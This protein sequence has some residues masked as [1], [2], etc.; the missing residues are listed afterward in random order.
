MK[1]KKQNNN[2][3]NQYRPVEVII[4]IVS[5]AIICFIAGWL[6]SIKFT[7]QNVKT[8]NNKDEL[9]DFLE[10]YDT[11]VKNYYGEVDK[12]ALIKGAIEGMI[13][14]L[15]DTNTTYIDDESSNNFNALLNGSYNGIGVEIAKKDKDIII[16]SVFDNSP[17]SNSGLKTGDIIKSV[18]DQSVDS[19]ST[20]EVVNL[21]KKDTT[22]VKLVI[23]R[24]N[25]E[26]TFD[27]KLNTVTLDSVSSKTF[28]VNNK[29]IGYI[30]ISIF[31][32]NTYEQFKSKLEELEKANIDSLIIDVRY[33]SGGH[34]TTATKII[35]LFLSSDKV[36]YQ[37]EDS[38]GTQKHYSQGT[39]TKE[40][41]I[42]VLVNGNSASASEILASA[43]KEQYNAILVGKKTYGKG[44]VQEL[45]KTKN[46]IQYKI[47]TQ[48]WLTSK[49]NWIDKQGIDVDYD[50]ELT[51]KYLSNPIDEN[52]SQLNKAIE[53]LK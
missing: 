9:S 25:K 47:T 51:D 26:L 50:V 4:L 3:L 24:D 39:I 40:Y 30:Y 5:T 29:K 13:D 28:E 41:P 20:S 22:Q 1:N 6:L 34:L 52:D 38:S 46:G 14:S 35:S 43:L 8:I 10:A 42:V 15:G 45:L 12:N 32:S 21:I 2:Y 19:M 44:T 27:L 7:N 18:N 33:N 31:A 37:I 17:A 36:I 23:Q 48:H 49:G 11:I 53:I 16:Y